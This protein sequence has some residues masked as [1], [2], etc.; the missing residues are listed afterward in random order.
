MSKLLTGLNKAQEQAVLHK[1]GPLLIVAGAGTGKT[2][3]IARRVA[4]LIENQKVDPEKILALTF[5]DK[6]TEEMEERVNDL[7]PLGYPDLWINT[8]HSFGERVLKEVALEVGLNPN[9]KL[10]SEPEQWLFIRKH[11]FDFK[12]EYYRPLGNPSRFIRALAHHFSRAKDEDITPEQYLKYVDKLEKDFKKTKLKGDEKEALAEE[13]KKTKELAHAYD[14]YQKLLIEEGFM[15]FGDL[16]T[17][18]LHVFRTRK[19]VLARYRKQFEYILV[20]EFCLLYTS[21][22]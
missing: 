4:W 18:T 10:L 7:L 16:I 5:M 21:D 17:N 3:V 11:L 9:F 13:V 14:T 19:S 22:A 8:F 12:L 1:D 6:A 20:D 15:D 2:T